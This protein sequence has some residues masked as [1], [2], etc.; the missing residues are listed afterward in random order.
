MIFTKGLFRQKALRF[1][2]P[3]KIDET[4]YT[5]IKTRIAE[6]PQFNF[7]T[8]AHVWKLYRVLLIISLVTCLALVLLLVSI[9]SEI[10]IGSGTYNRILFFVC[11]LI[12]IL[13]MRP[14]IYF[15]MLLFHF[16]KYGRDEKKFHVDFI[17]AIAES[18]NFTDFTNRFY[19]G[20]YS[21]TTKVKGYYLSLPIEPFKAFAE[22]KGMTTRL[23]IYKRAKGDNY[24]M[25]SNSVELISFIERQKG[26]IAIE[27]IDPV[28]RVIKEQL[29]FPYVYGSKR[30]KYL[31][32]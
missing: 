32:D 30:L 16:L 17:L 27:T 7:E 28:L 12:I 25:L 20:R 4:F 29:E 24:I 22:D 26:I 19:S 18:D 23:C 13:G 14:S 6:D 31:I 15:G 1:D 2:L 11:C 9:V 3:G 21:E 10:S 5:D 8:E